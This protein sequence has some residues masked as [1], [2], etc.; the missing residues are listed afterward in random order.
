[1]LKRGSTS[2]TTGS[3][4]VERGVKK[5]W[6][7]PSSKLIGTKVTKNQ[8]G[9]EDEL[10]VTED[11]TRLAASKGMEEINK[12]DGGGESRAQEWEGRAQEGGSSIKIRFGL[13]GEATE[14]YEGRARGRDLRPNRKNGEES[15]RGG[16]LGHHLLK[17]GYFKTEVNGIMEDTCIEVEEDEADRAE[18]VRGLDGVSPQTERENQVDDMVN[19]ENKNEK[20]P[21]ARGHDRL[22][23]TS[24]V[25]TRKILGPRGVASKTI[26]RNL[27]REPQPSIHLGDEVLSKISRSHQISIRQEEEQRPQHQ[28]LARDHLSEG[29]GTHHLQPAC[30]AIQLARHYVTKEH[31]NQRIKELIEAQVLGTTGD[32]TKLQGSPIAQDLFDMEIPKGF[33]TLKLRKYKDTGPKDHIQ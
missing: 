13:G 4:E 10:K 7:D 27:Q 32:V 14:F 25:S 26:S 6:V 21:P 2:G 8:S 5:R 11:R 3:G 29:T 31:M 30:P 18:V 22:P 19:P 1:M 17:M 33:Q 15:R 28:V 16:R 20:A 12:V 9:V 24:C 23:E